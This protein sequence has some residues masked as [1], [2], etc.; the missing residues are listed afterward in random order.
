MPNATTLEPIPAEHLHAT[1]WASGADH[2]NPAAI[3]D[4]MA[5]AIA[6]RGMP[7]YMARSPRHAEFLGLRPMQMANCV[8]WCS[9]MPKPPQL[10]ANGSN[11]MSPKA[12][13]CSAFPSIT[14]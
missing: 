2:A 8:F 4:A 13:P 11:A 10:S 3:R 12:S 14:V 7:G 6:V 1:A 5:E 9:A